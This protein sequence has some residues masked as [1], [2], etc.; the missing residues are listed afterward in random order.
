[1]M[2]LSKSKPHLSIHLR[3]PNESF[4]WCIALNDEIIHNISN[5]ESFSRDVGYLDVFQKIVDNKVEV[6]PI[7]ESLKESD[8]QKNN[9]LQSKIA[10]YLIDNCAKFKKEYGMYYASVIDE[11]KSFN[12]I[13][14]SDCNNCSMLKKRNQW[15]A[16]K[17]PT[18]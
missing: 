5:I 15:D 14:N 9:C 12:D 18:H 8:L 10:A 7:F 6:A 4:K 2:K 3:S 11:C 17:F 16:L 1:M 13:E